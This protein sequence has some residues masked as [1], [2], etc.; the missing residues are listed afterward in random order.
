MLLVTRRHFC[1][2]A[3]AGL[4]A[5]AAPPLLQAASVDSRLATES[6]IWSQYF[7]AHKLSVEDGLPQMF[8]G[9]SA[10]GYRRLEISAAWLTPDLLP[11]VLRLSRQ[12]EVTMPFVYTDGIMHQRE[13]ARQT[14]AAV[15]AMADRLQKP[16]HLEAIVFNPAFKPHN[17]LKTEEELSMQ[18]EALNQLG[19]S[20]KRRGLR[21]F[22]HAHAPEMQDHAREWRHNLRQ[23]EPGLVSICA[24]INWFFMGGA[25][26]LELLR[27]AGP[28]VASLHI[29]N[30]SRGIWLESLDERVRP[31]DVDYSAVA[32]LLQK[33]RI[34]PWLVVELAYMPKTR[35][36]R[37]LQ[38]DL[39]RSRRWTERRF[40]GL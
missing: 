1:A 6:Y 27:E 31:L 7:D 19:A 10:A 18:A 29:R 15:S 35:V 38:A 37:S 8:A 22:V 30:S 13:G 20:L 12:H 17:A 26:P 33:E 3:A 14:I 25:D 2:S 4:F 23:T 36:T 40:Q 11:L 32:A 24:D 28:R 16:L 39:L 34:S 9:V 5:A 21:L